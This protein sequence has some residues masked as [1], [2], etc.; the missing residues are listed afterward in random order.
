MLQQ[1][2]YLSSPDIKPV[3]LFGYIEMT[4]AYGTSG[5]KEKTRAKLYAS[6]SETRLDEW[7]DLEDAKSEN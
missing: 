1:I 7:I 2:I 6:N 5:I 3:I 4:A